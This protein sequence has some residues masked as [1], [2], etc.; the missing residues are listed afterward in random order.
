MIDST[1]NTIKGM[2]SIKGMNVKKYPSVSA[3]YLEEI[4]ALMGVIHGFCKQEFPLLRYGTCILDTQKDGMHPQCAFR[5]NLPGGDY[6]A[7]IFRRGKPTDDFSFEVN[8]IC[9][10][11]IAEDSI[12]ELLKWGKEKSRYDKDIQ[13]KTSTLHDLPAGIYRD[14]ELSVLVLPATKGRFLFTFH[15][16]DDQLNPVGM[17]NECLAYVVAE[18]LALMG[19]EDQILQYSSLE[20]IRS[21]PDHALDAIVAVR[22]YFNQP[23]TIPEIVAWRKWHAEALQDGALTLFFE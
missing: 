4:D 12:N 14:R 20:L 19:K 22:S 5:F 9:S 23:E 6:H 1:N 7:R 16:C 21:A 13:Q 11:Q 15:S 3:L 2:F 8:E 17:A 10:D 18:A